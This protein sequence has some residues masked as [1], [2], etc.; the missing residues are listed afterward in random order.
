MEPTSACTNVTALIEELECRVSELDIEGLN[1]RQILGPDLLVFLSSSQ[2]REFGENLRHET[3]S[4]LDQVQAKSREL[5]E[6]I[7]AVEEDLR[8]AGRVFAFV[9]SVT[10]RNRHLEIA[11][12]DA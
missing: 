7:E 5:R 4:R 11:T 8:V 1:D 2:G 10:H 6:E 12:A 3:Y 9:E